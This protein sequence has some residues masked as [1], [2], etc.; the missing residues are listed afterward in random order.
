MTECPHEN[1]FVSIRVHAYFDT[2]A[3]KEYDWEACSRWVDSEWPTLAESEE[4]DIRT[5]YQCEECSQSWYGRIIDYEKG[6][7]IFVPD[8]DNPFME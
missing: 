4:D 2:T 3:I 7:P 6:V 5:L 1:M 8:F